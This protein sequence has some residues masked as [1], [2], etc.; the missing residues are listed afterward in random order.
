LVVGLLSMSLLQSSA[1]G[2]KVGYIG[3]GGTLTFTGVDGGNGGRRTLAVYYSSAVAR[4]FTIAANGG[5]A[6]TV[7]APA[8]ADWN[9]VGSLSPAPGGRPPYGGPPTESGARIRT[10][11]TAPSG[12][13]RRRPDRTS[14]W[15]VVAGGGEPL[16]ASPLG[17]D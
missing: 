8:T 1:A 11:R 6:T 3:N 9:T 2:A 4:S 7:N 14:S 10:P 5:T 15:R 13:R 16:Q 12:R 17:G